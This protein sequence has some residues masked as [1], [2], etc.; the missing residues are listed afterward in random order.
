MAV[1]SFGAAHHVP[2]GGRG[3]RERIKRVI[4]DTVVRIDAQEHHGRQI[5]VPRRPEIRARV[6]AAP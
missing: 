4:D 3:A 1:S 2:T 5:V 6:Y